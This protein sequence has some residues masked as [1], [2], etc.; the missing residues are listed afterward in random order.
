MIAPH[1]EQAVPGSGGV[2]AAR[3]HLIPTDSRTTRGRASEHGQAITEFAMVLPLLAL[4]VLAAVLIGK[5]LYV[6]LQ[7]THAANEGARVASVNQPTSGTLTS[8]LTGEYALP[9]GT[10][11]AVCYPVNPDTN[12]TK[13]IGDPVQVDVYTSATWVPWLNTTKIIGA[14][15]MRLEQQATSSALTPDTG[16]NGATKLCNTP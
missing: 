9:G 5:A 12:T 6:Y 7:V 3:A 8:Y 14:A 1:R 4:F 13:Q 2:R 11:I 15:T 16:F 10:T